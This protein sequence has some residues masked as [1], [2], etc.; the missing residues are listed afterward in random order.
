MGPVRG[1]GASQ[2]AGRLCRDRQRLQQRGLRRSDALPADSCRVHRSAGAGDAHTDAHRRTDPHTATRNTD[3][4]A[5]NADAKAGHAHAKAG[6]ADTATRNTDTPACN[7]DATARHPNASSCNADAKTGNANATPGDPHTTSCHSYAGTRHSDA[8]TGNAQPPASDA[9]PA[10]GP[11]ADTQSEPD[12]DRKTH[13][14]PFCEP[15][16]FADWVTGGAF[17]N[18]NSHPDALAA[19]D[20]GAWIDSRSDP[21]R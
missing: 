5:C 8:K 4:P 16:R 14:E 20:A 3:T 13:G 2:G 15:D 11:N 21:G 17:P 12:A 9:H 19:P 10:A 1:H 6:D 7:A 18:C